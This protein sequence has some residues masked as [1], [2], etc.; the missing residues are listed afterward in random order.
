MDHDLEISSAQNPRIKHALK[1]RKRSVRDEEQLFLVEGYRE[2]LRACKF[3]WPIETLFYC[4]EYFLGENEPE[5]IDHARENGAQCIRCTEAV[6][7]KLSYRDRP[8][9]L[10]AIS[11]QG[12]LT[13]D[14]L[15]DLE[16]PFLLVA[17]NIEKPGNLGTILRTA[18]G[19]GVDA[20]IVTD[21]VT[22]VFN[23][24][25]V[26]ASVGTLFSVPFVEATSRDTI[27]WLRDQGIAILSTSPD[28]KRAYFE[29]NLE[30]PVA[31][32]VGS[33]QLGLTEEWLN[34]A[35]TQ[36]MIPMC[37]LADSLNVA[38]A[39]GLVAYETL[40]QRNDFVASE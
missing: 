11:P 22:D 40:R 4:P 15:A 10:L 12:H 30:G 36:V 24:N 32:V 16:N 34:V 31:W 3:T 14:A 7:K 6:F 23:P 18:D 26:R 25:T 17:N 8:D 5:L 13:L 1:L 21:P 19:A 37:G 29:V 33:E 39:A 2:V 35:D 9:G 27:D 28:A 20:V 38:M